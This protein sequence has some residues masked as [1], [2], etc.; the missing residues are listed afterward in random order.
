MANHRLSSKM[1]DR[2]DNLLRASTALL[3]LRE[4]M[5]ARLLYSRFRVT[6]LR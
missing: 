1:V 6:P 3:L 5:G 2:Q 4:D